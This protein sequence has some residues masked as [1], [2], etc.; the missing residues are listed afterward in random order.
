MIRSQHL[1]AIAERPQVVKHHEVKVEPVVITTLCNHCGIAKKLRRGGIC[2]ACYCY[3]RKHGKPRP[4]ALVM[5]DLARQSK[6]RWCMTCGYP[7]IYSSLRCKPCYSYWN[8]HG[9][10]RPRWLWDDDFCCINCGI[11]RKQA[12]KRSGGRDNFDK[13]MCHAC[14]NYNHKFKRPRP[15]DMW[16]KGKHGWC[17]CGF[18][19]EHQTGGF[20]LCNRCVKDYR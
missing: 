18:P 15:A 4:H 13:D 1:G 8:R 12:G 19:A 10:S 11:S 3:R 2:S 9:K 17:E 14:Y 6:A 7:E 20:N 16:G 5:H